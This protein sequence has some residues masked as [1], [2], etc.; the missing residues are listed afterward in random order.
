MSMQ[1]LITARLWPSMIK[2][3]GTYR[4]A[5]L[6]YPINRCPITDNVCSAPCHGGGNATR[7][8]FCVSA[9]LPLWPSLTC[10]HWAHRF[11]KS[12]QFGSLYTAL[13][14]HFAMIGTFGGFFLAWIPFS[15]PAM[16]G[17]IFLAKVVVNDTIVMIETMNA[18]RRSGL[19]VR[20]SA[21]RG[22][23]D[24]L[25]PTLSTTV[26]TVVGLIPLTLSKPMWMP[27]CNAIIFGL[28]AATL[29]S[30]LIVPCLYFL[31]TPEQKTSGSLARAVEG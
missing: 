25:R 22:S 29:S 23:A 7:K 9:G 27:L 18:H 5:E 12:L 19:S 26:T 2:T 14:I 4:F 21:A 8:N 3:D 11:G 13:S 20:E 1:M 24:R 10:R 15:F 31:M 6:T 28:I 30:Q 17:M 16:L